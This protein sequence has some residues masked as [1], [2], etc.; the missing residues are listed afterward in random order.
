MHIAPHNFTHSPV[1][2]VICGFTPENS[3]KVEI[4]IPLPYPGWLPIREKIAA[5]LGGISHTEAIHSCLLR[6]T[7]S[8]HLSDGDIPDQ[9]IS[10]A[11]KVPK[12]MQNLILAGPVSEMT[13]AGSATNTEITTRFVQK[14]RRMILIFMAQSKESQMIER[15]S[16]LSWFDSS[17][18]DIHSLF[19]MIVSK[20]LIQ[21][22]T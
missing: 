21:R 3:H 16:A 19:D 5:A 12:A 4:T 18:E 20:D 6:Y 13:I 9:L 10:I 11:P 1:E 8:F 22:I 7:D 17:R 2:E 14:N 15:D